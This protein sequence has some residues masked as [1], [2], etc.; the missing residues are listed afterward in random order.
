[1]KRINI[2]LIGECGVGKTW[3]MKQIIK[4]KNMTLHYSMKT[5]VFIREGNLAIAGKYDNSTFE[6]T[7]RLSMAVMKDT[8]AY[9]K[10]LNDYKVNGIFEG[11][12]F[13]NSKFIDKAQP[14]II[15]IKGNGSKGRELRGSNQT[16]RHL[17]SIKT[18][19][20]NIKPHIEVESSSE[21]LKTI[22]ELI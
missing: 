4:A 22:L 1:M 15:K 12:R 20:N 18:R 11:D 17:K 8:D 13:T 3:V 7:D 2:L 9:L 19:V 10:F 16:E 5:I 21:A 6:G 14:Y